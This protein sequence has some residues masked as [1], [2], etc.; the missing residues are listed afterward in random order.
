MGCQCIVKVSFVCPKHC[1]SARQPIWASSTRN[2]KAFVQANQLWLAQNLHWNHWK[3]KD[4][5]CT[6]KCK[7]V[8]PRVTVPRFF[9]AFLGTIGHHW[10]PL[11][12]IGHQKLLWH[13][14]I[15]LIHIASLLIS[16][17]HNPDINFRPHWSWSAIGPQCHWLLRVLECVRATPRYSEVLL[18]QKAYNFQ[19]SLL[20]CH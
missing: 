18:E 12:T 2:W 13:H 5:F 3:A 14:C 6:A 16:C 15:I 10:A 19:A 7:A 9:S 8:T 17:T 20:C 1:N 4:P 11:G